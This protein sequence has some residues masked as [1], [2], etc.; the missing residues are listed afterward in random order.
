MIVIID[1]GSQTTHLI[2]RRLREISIDTMIVEPEEFFEKTQNNTINGVILSGGPGDAYKSDALTIDAKLFEMNIPVL[3]ICYGEQVIAEI[4]GGSVKPGTKKE[5]GPA[6][7]KII[8]S[9]P[10]FNFCHPEQREGSIESMDSSAS[11]QND[12][13]TQPSSTVEIP[14]SISVWMNHGD[15][16]EKV[17]NGFTAIG[18]TDTIPFAAIAD[19]ERK[20][21]G[22]QFHPEVV[23]TQFGLQILKNF[24]VICGLEP[25][26]QPITKEF[27]EK[28]I[29][30]IKD[31]VG[32]HNVIGALSGGVDSSIACLMVHRAIGDQFTAVYIDSGLMRTGE[33][34]ELKKVFSDTYKMKVLIVDAQ[35]EFIDNLKGITDP[36]QK[37]KIIGKTFIDVLEREAEKFNATFLVQGTIYPDVIES[38]GSKHAKNIKSHHNVGGLPKD[39][40]VMLLEPLRNF[41]KDEVRTIGTLLKLPKSITHRH[42]F[43]GPGLAI[44]II[45]EVTEEKLSIVRRADKIVR[46]EISAAGLNDTL[47]QVFAVFTGIKTTGVRGDNRA[48]GE[49]IAIRAVESL[50]VMSSNFA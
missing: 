13:A 5:Y 27:I 37:R 8:K 48:Y 19:E 17:P 16:V 29:F 9:S 2:S 15:E 30:D 42:P 25:K 6:E 32:S 23:H 10:L 4:L 31:S 1:F 40:K 35:K 38:A 47:W 3:G 20:I 28:Q 46:N 24:A 44:R 18:V 41:Y 21:Y 7:L 11:P 50:D 36:E 12:N 45:G 49:T 39:M 33:T 22:I 14:K 26:D 43:P 34:E